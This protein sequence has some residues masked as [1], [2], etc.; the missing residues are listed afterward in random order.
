M[1]CLFII[2]VVLFFLMS[3]GFFM[4]FDDVGFEASAETEP[5]VIHSFQCVQTNVKYCVLFMCE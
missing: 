2:L 1:F 4:V 3:F 5:D